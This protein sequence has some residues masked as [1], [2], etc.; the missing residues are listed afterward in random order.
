MGFALQLE[1][2]YKVPPHPKREACGWTP[3]SQSEKLRPVTSNGSFSEFCSEMSR[4]LLW[5]QG[6]LCIPGTRLDFIPF[7]E[8]Y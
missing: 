6:Q 4:L 2:Y 7:S 1:L 5:A 8:Q 3:A